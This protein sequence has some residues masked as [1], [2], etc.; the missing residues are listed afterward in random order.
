MDGQQNAPLPGPE[1][2]IPE[3]TAANRAAFNEGLVN[4]QAQAGMQQDQARIDQQEQAARIEAEKNDP[5]NYRIVRTATGGM[6]F[7]DPTGQEVSVDEYAR[8]AGET[9]AGVLRDSEDPQ[10]QQFVQDYENLQTTINALYNEDTGTLQ[11]IQKRDPEAF[12]VLQDY[13]QKRGNLGD[14]A[15]DMMSDFMDYYG[16]YYGQNQNQPGPNEPFAPEFARNIGPSAGQRFGQVSQLDPEVARELPA[17]EL[18]DPEAIQ[19]R[20]TSE[21]ATPQDV[22]GLSDRGQNIQQQQQQAQQILE[23]RRADEDN[24]GFREDVLNPIGDFFGNIKDRGQFIQQDVGRG[25]SSNNQQGI[26]STA[27]DRDQQNRIAN[28]ARGDFI[29]RSTRRFL[30]GRG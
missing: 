23:Q 24:F 17:S 15:D 20:M 6:R 27:L 2:S 29:D 9:P 16:S 8:V 22:L 14:A 21:V 30:S 1:S 13:T 10:D 19:E 5:N 26:G 25:L 12:S 11:Q 4:Q 28:A 3:L 18:N 7:I